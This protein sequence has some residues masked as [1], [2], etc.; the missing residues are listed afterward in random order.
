[1]A[2]RAGGQDVRRHQARLV[3][4]VA[5]EAGEVIQAAALTMRARM[6]V[7]DLADQLSPT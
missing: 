6:T 1:M 2:L 3:Y 7:H 4:A 5:P